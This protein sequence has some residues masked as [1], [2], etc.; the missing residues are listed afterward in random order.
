M[1]QQRE[2]K[3]N[4]LRRRRL[5]GG[6]LRRLQ[7]LWRLRRLVHLA[8]RGRPRSRSLRHTGGLVLIYNPSRR[9]DSE[10]GR[11]CG[12]GE[13]VELCALHAHL[14]PQSQ[15]VGH[16]LLE[17]SVAACPARRAP[18]IFEEVLEEVHSP[19][20]AWQSLQQGR[21]LLRRI[22]AQGLRQQARGRQRARILLR[23]TVIVVEN[24]HA[25]LRHHAIG[26][27][28]AEGLRGR[29]FIVLR[30]S[31]GLRLRVNRGNCQGCRQRQQYRRCHGKRP[32]R[33]RRL[34]SRRCT[35]LGV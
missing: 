21:V 19:S 5:V 28:R 7:R 3:V 31:R 4:R 35:A 23:G 16:Q 33:S 32:A 25:R 6:M 11:L 8:V 13:L 22:V 1:L 30:G 14:F 18:K 20:I 17:L 2:N 15:V 24:T 10:R 26:G 27:F 9:R 34:R 12:V 29:S